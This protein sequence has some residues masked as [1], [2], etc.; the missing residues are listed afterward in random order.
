MH[1]MQNFN[2]LCMSHIG[3]FGMTRSAQRIIYTSV[4]VDKGKV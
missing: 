3:F 1:M 4:K 2:V